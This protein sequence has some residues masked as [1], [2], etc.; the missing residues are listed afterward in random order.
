MLRLV[1]FFVLVAL[2]ATLLGKL[3]WIGPLFDHTGIF[4]LLLVA[5]SPAAAAAVQGAL[6]DAQT[7]LAAA[8]QS[9]LR[10][11][12]WNRIERL[13][14]L[15]RKTFEMEL[16]DETVLKGDVAPA[17][18]GYLPLFFGEECRARLFVTTMTTVADDTE[19]YLLLELDDRTG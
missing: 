11:E 3:P 14:S 7:I 1:G 16:E 8:I 6:R 5:A 15:A 18:L 2:L 17:P 10:A 4:G 13:Q 19:R 9:F 12:A